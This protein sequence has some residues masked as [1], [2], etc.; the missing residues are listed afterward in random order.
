MDA[1]LPRNSG[2]EPVA[3][4]ARE[5][6]F[7][8]WML[9]WPL[10]AALIVVAL[11]QLASWLP[12]Y[13]TW[14][15]W[16]DHDVAATSARS[17][18]LGVLPY[19]DFHMNG[20]PGETYLFYALG[21]LGGWG[22]SPVFYG[23]DAGFLLVFLG[24]L[25]AWSLRRFG[26]GLPGL[27]G[28]IAFLSYYLSLDY[29]HAGQRD[30]HATCYAMLALLLAQGW[31]GRLASLVSAI[32]AA[33]ALA[34]RPQTVVFVPALL[35]AIV[36]ED[37]GEIP[38]GRRL[39][40]GVG[41]LVALA[42]CAALAFV[43][44]A[45]AGIFGDFLRS[46][47]H[48]AY[49][50]SYNRVSLESLTK[51]WAVQ[52]AEFR[53][54]VVPAAIVLLARMASPKERAT[55]WPWLAALAGVSVYKPMSPMA[56]SYLDLPLV[57]VWSIDLAVLAGLAIL[58]ARADPSQ[59]SGSRRWWACSAWERRPCGRSSCVVGPKPQGIRGLGGSE[60]GGL[61]AESA[62]GLPQG[63]G[64]DLGVLPVGGLPGD[65][66]ALSQKPH[67]ARDQGGERPQGRPGGPGGGRPP[68]GLPGGVDRL[69]PDGRREGR[70]ELR[71]I[72]PEGGGGFGRRLV[73]GGSRA[74]PDVPD[75]ADRGR[76]PPALRVRGSLRPDPGLAPEEGGGDPLSSRAPGEPR[77]PG[78]PNNEGRGAT[79][80]D[81]AEDDRASGPGGRA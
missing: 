12:H 60:A 74:E 23:F 68:F 49:G 15:Y 6:G 32:L 20:F 45:V 16:A 35:V 28:S 26:R 36:G 52:A 80:G 10:S 18:D 72:A 34:T 2:E 76:D 31:P 50:S 13:L 75:R 24:T 11:V 30:W 56:H 41:W 9:G 17:W 39:L 1:V 5:R 38:F 25:V 64:G 8:A 21:K 37:S 4:A 57:L 42:V 46:L 67:Q 73:A 7:A 65:C 44:L 66:W 79:D 27:V 58:G 14:P 33:F 22:R 69:A 71:R 77:L 63:V 55:A 40:R 47:R 62:A 19:R 3:G 43:P 78:R 54:L 53:W 48:V 70:A 61:P 29:S 59:E 81:E 51:A